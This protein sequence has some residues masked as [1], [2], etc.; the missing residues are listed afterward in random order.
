MTQL[1]LAIQNLSA[2]VHKFP[3]RVKCAILPW[4]PVV[5]AVVGTGETVSTES[6]KE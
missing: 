3:A 2:G 1:I 6:H 4:H 5:A